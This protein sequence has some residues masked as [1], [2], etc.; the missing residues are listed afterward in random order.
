LTIW[1]SQYDN[2]DVPGLMK[3][4][5]HIGKENIFIDVPSGLNCEIQHFEE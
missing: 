3:L 4:V 5:N 1:S 2:V